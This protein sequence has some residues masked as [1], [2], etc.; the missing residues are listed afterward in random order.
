[1]NNLKHNRMLF[2]SVIGGMVVL[3]F[4]GISLLNQSADRIE[5]EETRSI[6]NS[7]LNAVENDI[8]KRQVELDVQKSDSV[9]EATGL[10]PEAIKSDTEAAKRYFEPA[11]NWKSGEDYEKVR[12]QYI[13]SLGEDN[14]FTTTYLPPDTKIDT[15]DGLLS[16]IDFKSMKTTMEDMYIVPIAAEG[17]RIR[18]VAF[19][20]YF[21][22][23]NNEDLANTEALEKSEAIIEFTAAGD[24][25]NGERYVTEVNAHAGF[26]SS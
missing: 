2:L 18:Y 19:V 8:A 10:D 11:F 17:D 23:K 6:L 3:I 21:V 20:Q 9:K 16:Y 25:D 1:M 26:R 4:V 5:L 22:H 24:R 12:D 7:K 15:D 13:D 14:S